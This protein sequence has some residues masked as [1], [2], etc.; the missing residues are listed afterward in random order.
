MLWGACT[1][2]PVLQRFPADRAFWALPGCDL[3]RSSALD[4]WISLYSDRGL[5]MEPCETSTCVNL[6]LYSFC[7]PSFL[8]SATRIGFILRFAPHD[9]SWRASSLR[10]SFWT[11]T[12]LTN[13]YIS[14]VRHRIVTRHKYCDIFLAL[15]AWRKEP[16]FWFNWTDLTGFAPRAL[17]LNRRPAIAK[18]KRSSYSAN[19]AV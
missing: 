16:Y 8:W 2:S 19:P 5:W 6:S 14:V 10:T 9:G 12:S 7:P 15:S 18:R 13:C 3:I 1:G 17:W 11:L 4:F